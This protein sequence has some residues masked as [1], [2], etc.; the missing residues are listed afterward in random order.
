LLP[1]DNDNLLIS[2]TQNGVQGFPRVFG[3]FP[4]IKQN[5]RPPPPS[6]FW[7]KSKGKWRTGYHHQNDG[8]NQ[9]N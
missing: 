4:V 8:I 2:A 7:E 1:D 6:V 3:F 5:G 9:F